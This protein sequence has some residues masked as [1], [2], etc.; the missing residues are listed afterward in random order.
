MR[1]Y[2]FSFFRGSCTDFAI[3]HE[4]VIV[5]Y[6]KSHRASDLNYD[7]PL[8]CPLLTILSL[9]LLNIAVQSPNKA[10]LKVQS[11]TVS[12]LQTHLTSGPRLSADSLSDWYLQSEMRIDLHEEI[13][14]TQCAATHLR[15][16]LILRCRSVPAGACSTPSNRDSITLPAPLLSLS[17][18]TSYM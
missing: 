8:T 11:S 10:L 13:G 7:S 12:M 2:P 17:L 14:G 5:V 4:A 1:F 6:T 9:T 3:L 16:D 18:T 15:S